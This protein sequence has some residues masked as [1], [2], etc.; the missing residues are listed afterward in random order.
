MRSRGIYLLSMRRKYRI[1]RI[2]MLGV[3]AL[4]ATAGLILFVE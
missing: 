1:R 4:L 2:Y 3:A